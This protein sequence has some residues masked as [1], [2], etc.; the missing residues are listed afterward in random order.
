MPITICQILQMVVGSYVT[1]M[2]MVYVGEGETCKIDLSNS[3]LGLAMYISYFILFVVF[4][5]EK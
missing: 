1:V 2:G 5:Y 4:F 3:R